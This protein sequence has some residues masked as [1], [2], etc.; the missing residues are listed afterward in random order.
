M[1]RT[2]F[3]FIKI[4]NPSIR[5]IFSVSI[6]SVV[7]LICYGNSLDNNFV[8]DDKAV[9]VKNELV[10]D[11]HNIPLIFTTSY[12]EGYRWEGIEKNEQSLYRPL[13]IFSYNLN[14][15]ISGTNPFSYH[16]VN[17]IL[18]LFNSILVFLL[19]LYLFESWRWVSSLI[20]S[21]LFVTHPIHTE[22]VTGIV[23]RAELLCFCFYI[24]SLLFYLKARLPNSSHTTVCYLLSL[25]SYFL[26]LLSKESAVTLLGVVILIDWLYHYQGQ[27]KAML[28]NGLHTIK[29]NYLGFIL[30]TLVY[31]ILRFLILKNPL[32]PGSIPLLDN[33]L[34][35]ASSWQRIITALKI[36][37]NYIILLIF[38]IKLSADYSY[39]QIPVSTTVF[40]PEFLCSLLLIVTAVGLAFWWSRKMKVISFSLFFFFITL[41][42]TSNLLLIVGTI[43]AERLLYLPSLGFCIFVVALGQ[44][45]LAGVSQKRRVFSLYSLAVVVVFLI[46]LYALRSLIRNR[47]WKDEAHLFSSVVRNAPQSARGH[48]QMAAVYFQNGNYKLALKEARRAVEIYPD[49]KEAHYSLGTTYSKIAQYDKAVIELTRALRIHPRYPSAILNLGTSYHHLKQYDKAIAVYKDLISIR[50]DYA[51]A[52]NNLGI[53]YYFKGRVEKAI[54]A[55]LHALELKPDYA[56]ACKNLGVLY[57]QKKGDSKKSTYYLE[58][59]LGFNPGQPEAKQIRALLKFIR[60]KM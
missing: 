26:A 48:N 60:E 54:R 22:A 36:I 42:I 15:F 10:K 59:S 34:I 19:C 50:P 23:G 3:E 30:A 16:L 55:Y 14:H 5:I 25:G 4:H 29:R 6:I 18:H 7:S 27:L 53:S 44:K 31:V 13:V 8:F 56:E 37:G 2:T 52:Y 11:I 57:Y 40:E 21:L 43:M 47:D 9:I 28:E 38:P 49:Y 51:E 1:M 32:N 12:W 24:L 41:S 46:S 33:P 20:V 39:N 58:R 17:L 35:A 45:A